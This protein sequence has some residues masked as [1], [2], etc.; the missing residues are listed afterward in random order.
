MATAGT[1]KSW[2]AEVKSWVRTV[3]SDVRWRFTFDATVR[4]AIAKSWPFPE[5]EWLK[6]VRAISSA[7]ATQIMKVVINNAAKGLGITLSDEEVEILADVAVAA[8]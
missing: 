3:T 7:V 2:N 1:T 8:L 6:I 4:P 5:N